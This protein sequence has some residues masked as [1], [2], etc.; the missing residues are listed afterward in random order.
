MPEQPVHAQ[1]TGGVGL[2]QEQLKFLTPLLWAPTFPV[3]RILT[4]SPRLQHVRPY[5]IGGAILVANLH[6]FWL[7]NNP[8]LSDL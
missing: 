5:V 2:R 7:I 8:D 1:R 3:L 6:G 4:S